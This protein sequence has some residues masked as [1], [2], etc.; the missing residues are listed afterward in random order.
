MIRAKPGDGA[1]IPTEILK[2]RDLIDNVLATAHGGCEP[3]RGPCQ[4]CDRQDDENVNLCAWCNLSTQHGCAVEMQLRFATSAL[5]GVA[6][7]KIGSDKEGSDLFKLALVEVG[8]DIRDHH[9]VQTRAAQFL[10][11]SGGALDRCMCMWCS[12]LLFVATDSDVR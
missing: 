3:V 7:S 1:V 11:R 8:V 6:G 9:M 2:I 12:L 10:E 5:F 4:I